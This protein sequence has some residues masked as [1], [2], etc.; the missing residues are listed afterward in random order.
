MRIAGH[1][2]LGVLG[3]VAGVAGS[4]VQGGWFPLGVLLALGGCAGLFWGGALLTRTRVGAAAPA[5]GWLL[6]VLALTVTR[7]QGD[8][9]Y[10]AGA[11]SY[12]YLLGGMTVAVV[13]AT[14]APTERPLFALDQ[15]TAR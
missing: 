15:R 11:G 4:L 9:V 7:P 1:L 5:G 6:S 10:A 14:L 2:G 13:C 8:F 12:V 3:F